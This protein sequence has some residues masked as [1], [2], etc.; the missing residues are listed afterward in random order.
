M[1]FS[2][3][4]FTNL[5]Q[6]GLRGVLSL[7]FL[8][9]AVALTANEPFLDKPSNEWTEAEALQV[10][11]DSP[12]AQTIT[13]STQDFQCDH[14]H[15][16]F[17]ESLG[18]Y[19]RESADARGSITPAPQ[20]GA[21]K[22][23]GAEYLVRL[24][25]VKPMQAAVERLISLDH[26]KWAHYYSGYALDPSAKPTNL[27]EGWY[28]PADEITISIILKH[29]GP[30]GASFRDYL[31][32]EN[33]PGGGLKHISF[34]AGVNTANGV[35]TSALGGPA[36]HQDGTPCDYIAL[37]FPSTVKGKPLISHSNEKLEFRFIVN[38]RVFEAT[39]Y[40]NPTDLLEGTETI[41][42]IPRTVDEP[43]RFSSP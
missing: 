8:Y 32:R 23:D 29:P 11:N 25:S 31:L 19:P 43:A 12:W 7:A 27:A 16:A 3:L 35:M 37:S 5:F 22:P 26:A 10:L 42:H 41:L 9:G 38:Q 14:K 30:S 34:C 18:T 39:F 17:P 36:V 20:A 21:V 33:V 1:A 15:P 24:V 13:T 4:S 40:V 28:N 2:A 6:A